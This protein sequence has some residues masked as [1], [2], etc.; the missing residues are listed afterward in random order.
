MIIRGVEAIGEPPGVQEIVVSGTTLAR[1]GSGAG[2]KASDEGPV[3]EFEQA[4]AF[5]GL[6]NSH[7]HL[8]FN[9]YPLLGHRRYR[10]YLEWGMDIHRQDEARIATIQ[11]V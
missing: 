5:P 4:I 10:D 8:E 9:L 3:L 11:R 7:D 2:Q 6:T 1:V